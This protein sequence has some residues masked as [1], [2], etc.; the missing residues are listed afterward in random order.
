[1]FINPV[2]LWRMCMKHPYPIH[3]WNNFEIWLTCVFF[4]EYFCVKIT[5][6]EGIQDGRRAPLPDYFRGTRTVNTQTP[7][8]GS[9]C[10]SGTDSARSTPS[11]SPTMSPPP[12]HGCISPSDSPVP[13]GGGPTAIAT[14]PQINKFLAREP[15]DGCE[16]VALKP[17]SDDR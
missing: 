9:S 16:R 6:R 4:D 13:P 7:A 8:R 11:L 2:F 14:S 10:T 17:S 15:P 3:S 12:V 1:M 5:Q